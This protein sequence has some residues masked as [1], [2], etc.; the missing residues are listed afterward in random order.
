[1]STSVSSNREH[2]LDFALHSALG[3]APTPSKTWLSSVLNTLKRS[4]PLGRTPFERLFDGVSNK[5]II[6][7]G[8]DA[9]GK[10]TL[11]RNHISVDKGKDV[12]TR[13]PYVGLALENVCYP[14]GVT[15][16]T[17]DVGGCSP[18]SYLKLEETVCEVADAVVW[19][20]DAG[21]RDRAVEAVYELRRCVY[22][23]LEK[24]D[25]D[26]AKTLR[27]RAALVMILINKSDAKHSLTMRHIYDSLANVC[28]TKII[29]E[30]DAISGKGVNEAFS[31]L[32]GQ[33]RHGVTAQSDKKEKEKSIPEK[34]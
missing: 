5:R 21:D 30:T 3:P 20:I 14:S 12:E 9:G 11:L 4:M 34:Y 7:A 26:D 23:K 8:L 25:H 17:L 29:F 24:W 22:S 6:I 31:W 16:H 27:G 15:F 19:V 1:M 18:Q 10:S 28:D 2:W 32:A 33:L 13:I